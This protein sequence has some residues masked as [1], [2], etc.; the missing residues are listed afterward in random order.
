MEPGKHSAFSDFL[1]TPRTWEGLKAFGGS[2]AIRS[3]YFWFLFVPI[4]A[5]MLAPLAGKTVVLWGL[6]LHV[7]LPFSWQCFFF[8]AVG[9][10]G[11]NFI[12]DIRCPWIIKNYT[13]PSD[14]IAAGFSRLRLAMELQRL[15]PALEAIKT[16]DASDMVNL[17]SLLSGKEGYDGYNHDELPNYFITLSTF[18]DHTRPGYRTAA[19]WLY[20]AGFILLVTVALQNIWSVLTAI[21]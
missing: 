13:K 5:K 3:A 21:F 11:A 8:A 12:Y 2:R 19:T 15:K 4:V 9:F 10:S 17:R 20:Y 16:E 1:R 7:A 6:E 14:F 18:A